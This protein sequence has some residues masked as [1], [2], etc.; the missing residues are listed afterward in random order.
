MRLLVVRRLRQARQCPLRRQFHHHRPPQR[1]QRRRR[2]G[3]TEGWHDSR[4]TDKRHSCGG[5]SKEEDMDWLRR[6]R[7]L[8]RGE[9][10]TGREKGL[11]NNPLWPV[12]HLQI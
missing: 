2:Y 11:R 12:Q 6:H 8:R 3:R 7:H 4:R 1:P 10:S 5:Q 9:E